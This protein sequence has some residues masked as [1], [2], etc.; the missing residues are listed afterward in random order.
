MTMLSVA[1]VQ[2]KRKS[3]LG[4]Y[5]NSALCWATFTIPSLVSA[6]PGPET[7][8]YIS[9][10]PQARAAPVTCSDVYL[11]PHPCDCCPKCRH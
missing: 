10:V 5:Q 2:I 1:P 9:G 11:Q 3:K 6:G 7:S 8:T 4:L